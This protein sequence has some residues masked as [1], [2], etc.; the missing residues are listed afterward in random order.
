MQDLVHLSEV[1]GTAITFPL[2]NLEMSTNH[3][4][5]SVELASISMVLRAEVAQLDH[6]KIKPHLTVAALVLAERFQIQ[7]EQL[8]A[9]VALKMNTVHLNQQNAFVCS[10]HP[11]ILFPTNLLNSSSWNISLHL[12]KRI[13]QSG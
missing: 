4:I 2:G 7:L 12:H 8:I 5:Y 11:F 1:Q 13:L 9:R 3:L 10:L 6:S